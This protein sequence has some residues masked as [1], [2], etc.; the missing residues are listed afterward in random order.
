[1]S[2]L[3]ERTALS[4]GRHF[5]TL[6]C[7]HHPTG[8]E[9]LRVHVF[10]GF[11]VDIAGEWFYMTAGHILRDIRAALA[12][13]SKF[14]I[15]RLGDH[16]AGSKFENKAVPYDFKL[17]QWCVLEDPATGL[18]YA[19]VHLGGLYRQ[20][21][22]VGGVIAFEEHTW[23]DP[24]TEHDHWALVGIPSESVA[25]DGESVISAR[26]VLAPLLPAESPELSE[27]R[28]TNQFYAKLADDSDN[29]IRSVVGMSGGP[30]VA[31]RYVNDTWKYGVI[32]VQSAWYPSLRVIAACPFASFA[33]ALKPVV[34]EA[35]L[36]ARQ[37][38]GVQSAP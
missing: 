16:T 4:V 21:L 12:A 8:G 13:G 37:L 25:Y 35:L 24:Q 14:D 17:E 2:N 33:L 26:L 7:V 34:E 11:V 30:I 31:L 29:V 6:S 28:V 32:G 15:W 20:Q 36:V 3:T 38:Q 18:D 19:A 5:V 22:E 1:M 27:S 10:S 23:S 9:T